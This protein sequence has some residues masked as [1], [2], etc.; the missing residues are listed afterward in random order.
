MGVDAKNRLGLSQYSQDK[1]VEA[2]RTFRQLI[3]IQALPPG[4]RVM[5]LYRLSYAEAYNENYQEAIVAVETALKLVPQNAE[6]TFQLGWVQLQ[7]DDFE[8]SVR[9]LKSA[10]ALA[11]SDPKLEARARLPVGGAVYAAGDVGRSDQSV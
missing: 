2:A 10:I 3:A 11:E 1:F 8:A 9:S 6:L 7:A 4:D 5:A